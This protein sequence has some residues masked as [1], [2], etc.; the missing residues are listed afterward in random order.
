[1]NTPS[2][3]EK[4]LSETVEP[5]TQTEQT[6][7]PEISIVLPC[8]N[9]IQTLEVC[10][11]KINLAVATHHLHAEVIVADNGS[12]D[13]SQA[14]AEACG[15]RVVHVHERGYGAALMAGISA[16]TGTYIIMGDADDSYDFT[17][18]YPFIEQLRQGHDLVMGCRMPKAG[19]TILPGAMPWLHRWIG[20]PA[21]SRIGQI[22]FHCPVT[23]FHCGLRGFRREFCQRLD[24]R[25]T[26]MEF[27]SEMVIKATLL[28]AKISEIP[29]TLHKDGRNRPPHLRTWR[30]GWRHLRFMLLY[31]PRWLFVLPGVILFL[32][33]MFGG[34]FLITGPLTLGNITFDTN[35]LL[36]ASMAILTGF[37]LMTFGV[38]SKTFAISAGL[39][40]RD[41]LFEHTV[42]RLSLEVGIVCGVLITSMGFGLLAL[43]TWYWHIQNFG[44]L[45][46]PES[47]RLIIPGTTAL[48]LG[49]EM[50]FSCFLLSLLLMR[51]K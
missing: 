18:I 16:A 6:I 45:S 34:T 27:A 26:G 30:D 3:I 14:K 8:L 15:A 32:L 33:G 19:G 17:A 38:F 22:F 25:A 1:M 41:L 44:A 48:T 37:N 20:N 42:E 13:G 7:N 50:I 49:I 51:H 29:I 36:V 4:S 5:F 39:L 46:Y 10:L 24:L 47:L 11:R 12:D 43:G 2:L 21:L 35:T 9:E 23:D 31:C 28:G 40:P